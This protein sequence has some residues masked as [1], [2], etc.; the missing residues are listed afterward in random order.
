MNGTGTF[1]SFATVVALPQGGGANCAALAGTTSN[2]FNFSD[3]ASCG[4]PGPVGG[5]P[6]LDALANTG[7]PTQT[8]LPQSGSPLIDKVPNASCQADGAA[9]ITAD[10]RGLPRPD[11]GSPD[12]DIGAVEVQPPVPNPPAPNAPV[13]NA[14]SAVVIEPR[15]TG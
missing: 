10:Q 15:F 13:T 11:T 7:G 4:F 9:G 1:T 14:P 12:C 5:D 3:D 2:G 6:M 8:R